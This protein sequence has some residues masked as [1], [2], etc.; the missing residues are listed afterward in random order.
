MFKLTTKYQ[1]Y[2]KS[3]KIDAFEQKNVQMS[4]PQVTDS[5]TQWKCER[6]LRGVSNLTVPCQKSQSCNCASKTP[7]LDST[8]SHSSVP[9]APLFPPVLQT[10]FPVP[11]S[12]PRASCSSVP[13]F[14]W[15][16]ARSFHL[17]STFSPPL[18]CYPLPHSSAPRPCTS[19]H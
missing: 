17:S 12:S 5:T 7:S 13:L 11:V 19:P 4:Q 6:E 1:S 9:T 3:T 16:A 8:E 15:G 10:Y 2:P 14:H 18:L